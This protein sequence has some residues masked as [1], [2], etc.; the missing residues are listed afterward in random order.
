MRK[1]EFILLPVSYTHLVPDAG[2]ND[3]EPCKALNKAGIDVI[4]LDHHIAET[5]NPYAIVVNNQ[6]CG[7]TNKEFSGAGITYKFLQAIDEELWTSFADKYI[8][9]AAIGNIAD[10][11]DMRSYETKYIADKGI[12]VSYTH[13]DVYKRQV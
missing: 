3:I 4:I 7:Y 8:D 2:T 13:L 1:S 6:T 10:V 11:M 12:A 9:L 5:E